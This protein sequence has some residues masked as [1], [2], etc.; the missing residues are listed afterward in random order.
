MASDRVITLSN[1]GKWKDS[2]KKKERKLTAHGD[3][4]YI[5][6]D[7]EKELN[8]TRRCSINWVGE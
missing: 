3:L 8:L 2:G 6:N 5:N 1:R 4:F 7:R